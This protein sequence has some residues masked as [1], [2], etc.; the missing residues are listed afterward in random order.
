M[1]KPF[2]HFFKNIFQASPPCLYDLIT[3]NHYHPRCGLSLV[4]LPLLNTKHTHHEGFSGEGNK[5]TFW[6]FQLESVTNQVFFAVRVTVCRKWA[7]WTVVDRR[8]VRHM[9]Q[10][11]DHIFEFVLSM[12]LFPMC[13]YIFP[14]LY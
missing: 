6:T 13:H 1:T 7:E 2:F 3:R 9:S 12:A 10:Q 8:N 4:D 11:R 14:R 5:R